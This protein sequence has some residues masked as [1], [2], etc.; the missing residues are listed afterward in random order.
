MFK[1]ALPILGVT[2]SVVAE[3]FYCEQL[4]FR[5]NAIARDLGLKSY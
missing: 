2:S 1:I 4:G 3:K 5:R